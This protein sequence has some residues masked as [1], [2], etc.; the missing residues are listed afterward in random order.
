M[1]KEEINKRNEAIAEF[2]GKHP[3][4]IDKGTTWSV[5]FVYADENGKIIAADNWASLQYNTSWDWL[6]PVAL[7]TGCISITPENV[8]M[9]FGGAIIAKY[10]YLKDTEIITTLFIAVSDYCMNK[11]NLLEWAIKHMKAGQY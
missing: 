10:Q 4:P 11:D 1:I 5:G 8:K 9:V 7:K 3:N 6:M 2:M